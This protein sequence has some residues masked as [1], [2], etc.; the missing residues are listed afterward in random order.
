MTRITNPQR[1]VVVAVGAVGKAT[2][3][4]V[5]EVVVE[6]VDGL[7]GGGRVEVRRVGE[8]TLG[9]TRPTCGIRRRDVLVERT[10]EAQHERAIEVIGQPRAVTVDEQERVPAATYSPI[11]G[12]SSRMQSAS[13]AAATSR[14]WSM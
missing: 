4:E 13:R 6:A 1:A 12:T 8:G 10:L 3:C 14:S 7:H 9:D 11:A 2:T 5:A